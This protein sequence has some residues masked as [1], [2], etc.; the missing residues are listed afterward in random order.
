VSD[1][2][3]RAIP[4]AVSPNVAF[5]AAA[6]AVAIVAPKVAAFGYLAIALLAVLRARG[7][8]R[9]PAAPAS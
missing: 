2:E 5:Y 6:T 7:D 3:V 8:E 4:V 1:E 9:Q